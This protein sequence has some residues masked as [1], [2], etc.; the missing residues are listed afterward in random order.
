MIPIRSRDGVA[1]A[2]RREGRGSPLL[3]VHGSGRDGSVW[4]SILPMLTSAFDV[5]CMDRRGH[6]LSED[7]D[8]YRIE[9]EYDDVAACIAAMQD[10]PVD[11]VGHSYGGLCA[12]G[13][14][15]KGAPV[16]RLVLFEPPI[17]TYPGAYYPPDLIKTMRRALA[18]RDRDRAMEAFM[19]GVFRTTPEE[20]E[21]MK[22]LSMWQQMAKSAPII[23]RELESVD[24]FVL[25]AQDYRD[26]N[27]PT[28]LILGGDSPPQYRATIEA[29]N[30]AL[31]GSRIAVLEGQQ[32]TA[33]KTAPELFAQRI[34]DFLKA[35]VGRPGM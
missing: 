31:P 32:H 26:W 10:G 6:G 12:L 3:L 14:A 13:A 5:C 35:P 2:C 21:D 24:R 15:R 7:S 18:K 25:A 28:L 30:A 8:S 23:L 20:L 29:L 19:K 22:S 34:V 9:K 1:I 33:I 16:R 17:P 27:I 11:V 4:Q